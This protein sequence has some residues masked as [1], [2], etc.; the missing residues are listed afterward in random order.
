MK[1]SSEDFR[2]KVKDYIPQYSK[3]LRE[4]ANKVSTRPSSMKIRDL[5]SLVLCKLLHK[6]LDYAHRHKEIFILDKKVYN[7]L[8]TDPKSCD[9]RTGGLAF[10]WWMSLEIL[11]LIEKEGGYQLKEVRKERRIF[12][13][14]REKELLVIYLDFPLATNLRPDILSRHSIHTSSLSQQYSEKVVE[15]KLS[16]SALEKSS[17]QI[18]QYATRWKPD[19]IAIL[20]GTPTHK[21]RIPVKVRIYDSLIIKPREELDTK[22]SEVVKLMTRR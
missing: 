10:Q 12:T 2:D 20:V 13:F 4:L 11:D 17:K 1:T 22:L 5:L 7:S 3:V 6:L 9:A 16:N 8:F 19:N 21:I 18:Q 14:E 15:I